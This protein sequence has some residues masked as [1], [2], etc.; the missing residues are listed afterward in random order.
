MLSIR[1]V[2][3]HW[4]ELA[5]R[6]QA[7]LV[8]DFRDGLTQTEIGRRLG[9]SQ[10]HVSRLRARALGH[11]RSRLL[12]LADTPAGARHDSGGYPGVRSGTKLVEFAAGSGPRL[13][14][15]AGRHPLCSVWI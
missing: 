7:V 1:A 13:A 11:L 9:I 15:E 8:M 2:G 6:E 5:P 3:T 14:A 4:G 12:D 10:M